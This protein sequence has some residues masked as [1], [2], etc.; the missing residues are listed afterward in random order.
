MPIL[1]PAATIESSVWPRPRGRW[2]GVDAALPQAWRRGGGTAVGLSAPLHSKTPRLRRGRPSK[3]EETQC[4]LEISPLSKRRNRRQASR[5]GQ[6]R[7]AAESCRAGHGGLWKCAAW[8]FQ[9]VEESEPGQRCGARMPRVSAAH[10]AATTR[11]AEG[12]LLM[13]TAIGRGRQPVRMTEQGRSQRY[14]KTATMVARADQH[15][16]SAA[17]SGRRCDEAM[18]ACQ[19]G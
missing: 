2:S 5:L 3:P 16:S 14:T 1:D 12:L 13:D 17:S 4:L 9:A 19:R 7:P 11:E 18:M 6:P 8:D 10:D 15:H